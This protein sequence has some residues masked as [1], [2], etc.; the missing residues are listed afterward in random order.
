[1]MQVLDAIL[2]LHASGRENKLNIVFEK[3]LQIVHSEE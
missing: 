3:I 2:F 1:M